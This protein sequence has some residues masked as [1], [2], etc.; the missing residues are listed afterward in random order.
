MTGSKYITRWL[1]GVCAFLTAQ[2]TFAITPQEALDKAKTK[3]TE[4]SSVSADFSMKIDGRTVKGNIVSKGSK[5]TL[6]SGVNS[7]WYNGKNLYTY[8]PAKSETSVFTPTASELAEVNP[9][10]YLNSASQFKA[11]GSKTRKAGIETVVLLP[12]KKGTGV[13]SVTI[14]LDAKTFLPKTINVEPT[15]GSII[16]ITISNIKLNLRV[17]DSTFEYPKAKYPKSQI[18]DFR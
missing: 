2:S 1:L 4:A 3:L 9:L 15:S 10:L 6:I 8:V 18:I 7:N 17:A 12:I 13:K 11:M 14:G 16:N 5:F